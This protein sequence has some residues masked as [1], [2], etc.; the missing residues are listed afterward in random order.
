M[1]LSSS[2][3]GQSESELFSL[4]FSFCK[5][6]NKETREKVSSCFFAGETKKVV[7][8]QESGV[9]FFF[10][11]FLL[12]L[13]LPPPTSASMPLRPFFEPMAGSSR[14][15]RCRWCSSCCSWRS[16]LRSGRRL[17]RKVEVL[18]NIVCGKKSLKRKNSRLIENVS[19]QPWPRR[20]AAEVFETDQVIRQVRQIRRQ[21]QFQIR[22]ASRRPEKGQPGE[23][24]GT[25]GELEAGPNSRNAAGH[26]R[27][28]GG[29]AHS[30]PADRGAVRPDT[31][32]GP[33]AD[34]LLG[35][36]AKRA[37]HL[38]VLVHVE[39]SGLERRVRRISVLPRH[40][41]ARVRM[42]QGRSTSWWVRKRF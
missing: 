25:G 35:F 3:F 21:R 2:G 29:R 37:R 12:L 32:T 42:R 10:F 19:G 38:H 14:W 41:V 28:D 30:V 26:L 16:R 11:Y 18:Q 6:R 1:H 9:Q 4:N 13:L 7:A 20:V 36:S 23:G 8:D 33:R 31:G 24:L 27:Q 15:R 39:S 34:R 5:R 22:P 40:Q 17:V